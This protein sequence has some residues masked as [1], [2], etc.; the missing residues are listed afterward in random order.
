MENKEMFSKNVVIYF[1]NNIKF[2][3]A[4]KKMKKIMLNVIKM[5]KVSKL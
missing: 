4:K 5:Q 2:K 3:N 1:V